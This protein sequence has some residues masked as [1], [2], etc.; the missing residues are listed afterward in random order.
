MNFKT[1]LNYN[2]HEK[3]RTILDYHLQVGELKEK[4]LQWYWEGTN[5]NYSLAGF[6]MKLRRHTTKYIVEYYLPSGLF[7]VTS[8]VCYSM[9]M[10]KLYL[11]YV[12]DK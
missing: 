1:I 12:F 10:F 7:V 4:D 5:R 9:P 11:T 2:K 3:K 8:W 6:E